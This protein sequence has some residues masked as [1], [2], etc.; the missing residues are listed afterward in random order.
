M[1]SLSIAVAAAAAAATFS[2]SP[3][4]IAKGAECTGPFRQCAVSVGATCSRDPDGKQRMTYWDYPGKVMTFERCVGAVFEANGQP[5]PYK[6]PGGASRVSRAGLAIPY[7]EL[8]Y[9]T[10]PDNTD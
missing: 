3:A 5:D 4:R 7:T 6:I 9:P 10:T 8:L 1:K 2:I